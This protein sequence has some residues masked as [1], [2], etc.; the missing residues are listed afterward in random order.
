MQNLPAYHKTLQLNS[1]KPIKLRYATLLS[2][3]IDGIK[4]RYV[5]SATAMQ[6]SK[7]APKLH[8]K[9]SQN[10]LRRTALHRENH[11]MP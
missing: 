8:A 11:T 6:L 4:S 9:I 1:D 2:F 10:I 3:L 5:N 7:T